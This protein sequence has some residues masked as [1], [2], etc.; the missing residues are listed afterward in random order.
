MFS[1]GGSCGH[2]LAITDPIFGHSFT[3]RLIWILA[4]TQLLTAKI[5][6]LGQIY[7]ADASAG[8]V[9]GRRM[10]CCRVKTETALFWR[11]ELASTGSEQKCTIQSQFKLSSAK[12]S[13]VQLIPITL[14]VASFMQLHAA[15]YSFSLSNV[16]GSG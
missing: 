13:F 3:L 11:Q 1:S 12:S 7:A 10:V 2:S 8:P 16:N 15:S 5:D 4:K 9:E 6:I 14:S